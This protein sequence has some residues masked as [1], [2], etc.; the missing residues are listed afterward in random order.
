VRA[1]A[2][3]LVLAAAAAACGCAYFNGMYYAKHYTRLAE[4]AERAGRTGDA[5]DRWQQAEIHA[6]S[7]ISRHPRSHWVT[8]A[9]LMR[10]RALVHLEAYSDAALALQLALRGG[11]SRSQHMEELGLIGHAYLMLG[12]LDSAAEALDTAV[13]ARE[14]DVRNQ[15]LLDRGRLFVQ[16]RQPDQAR[17]DLARSRDPRAP[18]DLAQVD[19]VLGDTAAAGA[20]YDSLAALKTFPETE[21]REGLDSLAG[22]GAGG[23]ASQLVDRLVARGGLSSGTKARLMLDDGSRRLDA[24]DTAGATDEFRRTV[25]LA[26]DSIAGQAAAVQLC[27]LGIAA[28][29][30]DSEL[31]PWRRKLAELSRAGG[32]AGRDAFDD[33]RLLFRL[34]SLADMTSAG[35]AFWFLRAELLRDSLHAVRL[36]AD[37]FADMAV[38][39][40][41][42]PWAPKALVAAIAGGYAGADSL[43]QVLAERYADSPYARAALGG[44]TVGDTT[45]AVLEDSL[46]RVLAV[47]E[48]RR[49]AS[50]RPRPGVLGGVGEETGPRRPTPSPG[51]RPRPEPGGPPSPEPPL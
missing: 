41:E 20:L 27:R 5:R 42:S 44:G 51:Q 21:W 35:D 47:G 39:Y 46:R 45:Y 24:A 32:N 15:A 13:D 11:G 10:G 38:R 34:D 33:L 29:T 18:Y 49:P 6:E 28:A 9:Q 36:A 26:P 17:E 19:L 7:L 48:A 43:R 14:R 25:D 37:A 8:E 12:M 1:A 2:R 22:A 3:A 31:G 4:S 23:H 30:T 40:P 50:G 16:R